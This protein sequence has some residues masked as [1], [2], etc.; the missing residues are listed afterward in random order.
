VTP[1]FYVGAGG[2]LSATDKR[3]FFGFLSRTATIRDAAPFPPLDLSVTF[4][5]RSRRL[6]PSSSQKR[7]PPLGLFGVPRWK[8]FVFSFPCAH[9]PV[10]QQVRFLLLSRRKLRPPLSFLLK[11]WMTARLFSLDDGRFFSLPSDIFVCI[12]PKLANTP[13]PFLEVC[14]IRSPLFLFSR[15][16]TG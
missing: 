13:L 6:S 9:P 4:S 5:Y 2:L 11:H 10:C 16:K 3:F 7:L 14:Y 8:I 1:F 12:W 15:L